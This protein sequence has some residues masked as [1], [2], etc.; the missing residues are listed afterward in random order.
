VVQTL[1]MLDN[2]KV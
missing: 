2:V 1:Y